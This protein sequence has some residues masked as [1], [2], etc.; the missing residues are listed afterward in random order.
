MFFGWEVCWN[1]IDNEISAWENCYH[2]CSRNES[3]NNS[4]WPS[5]F[6]YEGLDFITILTRL[7]DTCAQAIATERVY[8][9]KPM[10]GIY[11]E[12][13][14]WINVMYSK[15][16]NFYFGSMKGFKVS[17]L[18]Q[19][20]LCN[21]LRFKFDIQSFWNY[22]LAINKYL[23]RRV[24]IERRSHKYLEMLLSRFQVTQIC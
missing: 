19:F 9:W 10:I 18:V 21:L 1:S 22:P 8:I 12:Q 16:V 3:W 4:S 5:I 14:I 17:T 11:E 7:G 13:T 6:Q 24:H 20:G 23:E 15:V 2:L